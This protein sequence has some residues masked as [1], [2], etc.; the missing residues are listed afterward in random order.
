MAPKSFEAT[1][2]LPGAITTNTLI[3]TADENNFGDA[4]LNLSGIL[5]EGNNTIAV[6]VHQASLTSSDIGFFVNLAPTSESPLSGFS[7]VDDAFN[8]TSRPNNANGNLDPNGGFTG[9]A[10]FVEVGR[11]LNNNPSTSGGWQRTFTLGNTGRR[12][13]FVSLPHYFF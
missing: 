10:L 5:Q 12:Y 11:R 13:H 2:F 8:N 4:R 7:Y 6:E 1:L 9:G 3:Q